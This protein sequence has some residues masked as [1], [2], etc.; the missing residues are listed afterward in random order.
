MGKTIRNETELAQLALAGIPKA[1]L[2]YLADSVHLDVKQVAGFLPVTARNL[3][4]YKETDLLSD[5]V[6][7]RLI[8]L[9]SLFELGEEIL[10]VSYFKDW[11]QTKNVA[12]GEVSPAELL[13]SHTGIEIVKHE[14]GR[15]AHGIF[16]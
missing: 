10:G 2:T 3:H 7:D 14:L 9:A 4:R 1:T 13:K 6:S 8:G 16:A 15:I 12:L 5:V 11:L